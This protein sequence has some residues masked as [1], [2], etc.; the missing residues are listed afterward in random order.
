M[1]HSTFVYDEEGEGEGE[2]EEEGEGESMA[3]HYLSNNQAYQYHHNHM[4]LNVSK[5][6]ECVTE[7]SNRIKEK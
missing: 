3:C 2:G 1:R 4:K 7:R 6:S 5:R